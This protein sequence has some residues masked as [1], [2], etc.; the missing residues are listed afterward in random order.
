MIQTH[1]LKT[2]KVEENHLGFQKILQPDKSCAKY[3]SRYIITLLYKIEI[4]VYVPFCYRST[5]NVIKYS[6]LMAAEYVIVYVPYLLKVAHI[7]GPLVVFQSF[8]IIN[9][10]K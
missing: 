1:F 6:S 2:Y 10:L 8:T 7:V 9:V 5:F 4:M 3:I